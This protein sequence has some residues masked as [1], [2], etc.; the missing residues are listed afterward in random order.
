MLTDC[1]KMLV[2]STNWE[3][4]HS[5]VCQ[6]TCKSRYKMCQNARMHDV[7]NTCP[8]SPMK[9]NHKGL[10]LCSR[11]HPSWAS[12]GTPVGP[13]KDTHGTLESGKRG[14]RG[15]PTPTPNG[16]STVSMTHAPD[17][18]KHKS[19]DKQNGLRLH[20]FMTQM[21]SDNIVMWVT[22][23]SIVDWVYSKTQILLATFRLEINLGGSLMYLWKPN[24]CPHQLDV[25]EANVSIPQF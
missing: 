1:L 25:Q 17:S 4:R 11:C 22:R 6:Q 12:E 13:D 14:G 7:H 3:T 18:T 21:T 16:R 2:P 23:L 15:W 9:H 10:A 5:V 24:L 20:T 8:P 19:S